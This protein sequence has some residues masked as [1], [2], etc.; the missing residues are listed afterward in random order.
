MM[1]QGIYDL[2]ITG[3]GPAGLGAA[4]YAVRAGLRTAV[5]D[6]SP[7]A[8]GQVLST[9]EVDNYLGR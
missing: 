6:R 2:L 9:Y 7:V 8:G 1:G 4:I 3:A 5:I